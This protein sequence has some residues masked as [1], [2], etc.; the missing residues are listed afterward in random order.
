M[1]GMA[2]NAMRNIRSAAVAQ[3]Q[4]DWFKEVEDD[5]NSTRLAIKAYLT[6]CGRGDKIRAKKK[7]FCIANYK[8]EVR[9]TSGTYGQ[10]PI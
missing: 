5:P 4:T 1:C 7:G 10:F 9:Q 8:E 3:K 6:K 2:N